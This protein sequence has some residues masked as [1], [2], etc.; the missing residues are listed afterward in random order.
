MAS[1]SRGARR[2]AAAA[3]TRPATMDH[4]HDGQQLRCASCA[5]TTAHSHL[6][7]R[8]RPLGSVSMV[9]LLPLMVLLIWLGLATVAAQ[10]TSGERELPPLREGVGPLA[11][12]K[13]TRFLSDFLLA[14][15]L[16]SCSSPCPALIFSSLWQPSPSLFRRWSSAARLAPLHSPRRNGTRFGRRP[17]SSSTFFPPALSSSPSA[18]RCSSRTPIRSPCR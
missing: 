7:R 1:P 18:P 3:A 5:S 2:H 6:P 16:L 14:L 11:T 8:V 9:R 12:R 17:P 15:C 13:G 10:T 4:E